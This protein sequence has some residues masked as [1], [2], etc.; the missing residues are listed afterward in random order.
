M[1]NIKDVG[2]VTEVVFNAYYFVFV[3]VID[4]SELF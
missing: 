3:N 4:L 1:Q 2:E